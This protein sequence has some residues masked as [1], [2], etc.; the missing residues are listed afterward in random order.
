MFKWGFNNG[1]SFFIVGNDSQRVPILSW[2]SIE[3]DYLSEI[4]VLKELVENG[5]ASYTLD[6]C[7]VSADDIYRAGSIDHQILTIPEEYPYEIYVQSNGQLNQNSFIFEYD[8]YDFAPNGNKL[9]SER[10]GPILTIEGRQYLLSENQFKLCQAMDEFNHLPED[11]RFFK[12][13]LKRFAD[14][15]ALTRS[16]ATL[17]DS[18]L[19]S[20]DAVCFDKIKIDIA[21]KNN[22]LEVTPDIGINGEAFIKTFDKFPKVQ[23][24][25]PLSDGQGNVI[26]VI[27]DEAQQEQLRVVKSKRSVASKDDIAELVDH[28]EN[29]FDDSIID[30]SVLYSDRVVELGLYQP[31]FYPF[32]CP[33]KSAWIPGISI[34]SKID[35]EKRIFFKNEKELSAFEQKIGLAQAAGEEQVQWMGQPIPVDE[36]TKFVQLATRQFEVPE[37]P[38]KE[39]AGNREVLIIKENA[40]SLEYVAQ[41]EYTKFPNHKFHEIGNLRNGIVL[42]D[43]QVGGVA[44]LQTLNQA[45]FSGCLLA[46][47]MGLGKTLQILYFIEWH[48]QLK[49]FSNKP[50][51]IVAPVSLLENWEN[52]Y[53][54]FFSSKSLPLNVLSSSRISR[55]FDRHQVAELQKKQLILTNYETLRTCQLTLCAI[56]FSIV[57]LDEAQKIK[58]PGTLVTNASKALKADFKI[59]MTGTPVENTL[60]DIWCLMDF[61]SPGLLGNAKDFSKEYQKPLTDSN[62]DIAQLGESLRARIGNALLRRLKKDILVDFPKKEVRVVKQMMPLKQLESYLA[63]VELSNN[64][65]ASGAQTGNQVLKSILAIRSISDHPYLVNY[66][67]SKY[68]SKELVESSAKLQITVQL[69]EE[70]KKGNEKAIIFADRKETQSMLQ[71]V[72]YD[73]FDISPSII[74]G[75]TPVTKKAEDKSQMSRQQTIDKFQ[76]K[77]GFSVIIMSPLA[78]G[79][80]LNVTAANHVIHYSRHWNPAKEEQATDR[81]YRIGQVKDVYVYYPMAVFPDDYVDERGSNLKSFDEILSLLL[82]RKQNLASSTL[83][84]TEQCEVLPHEISD[85]LFTTDL[86][87]NKSPLTMEETNKLVPRLFEAY[88]A[89]L[90]DKQGYFT[91]LTPY[92]SDKG[93]DVVAISS[94]S[95]LL[96]QVKQCGGD[97]G[98]DAIKEIVAAKAFY[99]FKFNCH[100]F[101]LMVITNG[102]FTRGAQELAIVNHV[103]LIGGKDFA[104]MAGEYQITTQDLHLLENQR[105]QSF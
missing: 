105:M 14:I 40:E 37:R 92:T 55:K 88:A 43:H 32:V 8:F 46:D 93:A 24:I 96:M 51:L 74:N 82:A 23:P 85:G 29:V 71:R 15:K 79:V 18:Y 102:G 98:Q 61:S 1:F 95:N 26:R 4:F 53:E 76:R 100:D 50:Y 45:S 30:W 80:G 83:F 57:V 64:A 104:E 94:S 86:K 47:D 65:K 22:V 63:E 68:S 103:K 78:A 33:Y 44:W 72:V 87:V 35:G 84:P 3:S 38:V 28:P 12:E 19:Q 99:K 7:D 59:G 39:H 56:D 91:K 11:K 36:A 13:N 16:A 69:L 54:R 67:L 49:N 48:A 73:F 66:Q 9:I 34:K 42:K 31:K 25:Y 58:T 6:T 97:V 89:A 52:E 62:A 2:T 101:D 60:L 5:F 75:D 77:S 81:A 27:F 20:Q 70:I 17:L 41:Q 10:N 90:Y 21:F